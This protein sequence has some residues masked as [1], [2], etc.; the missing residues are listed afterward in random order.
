MKHVECKVVRR[1]RHA[2]PVLLASAVLTCCLAVPLIARADPGYQ[3]Q[4]RIGEP[5]S[6]RSDEFKRDW[7]LE[8]I[9][10]DHAYARGL[11]GRGIIVGM[12]D[13]GVAHWHS[14]LAGTTHLLQIHDPGCVTREQFA[15]PNACFFSDGGVTY[16]WVEPYTRLE[17]VALRRQ[18]K[19]GDI[20]ERTF[21]TIL[22][23]PGLHYDTH[24]THVA[25]SVAA[26]RDGHGMH[27]VA[28]GA[29]L[30]SANK[31]SDSYS[32]AA[33]ALGKPGGVYLIDG[34]RLEARRDV[35]RQ[36]G[37][38]KVRIINS[39]WSTPAS[40]RNVAGLDA[41]VRE[42]DIA[43]R[44]KVY[45]DA[46]VDNDL[47]QVFSVG[48]FAGKIASVYATL[49]RYHPQAESRWLSVVNVRANGTLAPQSGTCG[50]SK[51]WCISAPGSDIYSSV[52]E[53]ELTGSLLHDSTGNLTG[54]RV[55][56]DSAVS[57][58]AT[59]TGTSMAAPHVSGGL[60]LLME[61][62]P[63]LS[64]AQVRDVLLT[65]ARDLGRA[66]VDD[67]YGW[68]MMD[69]KRAIDGPAMLRVDTEVVM[70]QPAG[71]ERPWQDA[72]WDEWRNDI[73]GPGRLV[74]TGEGWLR[75]SGKAAFAGAEIRQGILQ[76]AGHS[77]LTGPVRVDGGDLM[78]SG[79]LN[80]T[81][82]VVAQG[83]AVIVGE[84]LNGVTRV[85]AQG[86]L[87]GTGTIAAT[88]I[89]G[90]IAPGVEGPGLLRIEGDYAQHADAVYEADVAAAGLSDQLAVSGTARLQG[91]VRVKALQ[92][93]PGARYRIVGAGKV[94]GRFSAVQVAPDSA[95][96]QVQLVY[97]DRA[98]DMVVK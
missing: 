93:T 43:A 41:A 23:Y 55:H 32:D 46:V 45:A 68:G 79:V 73:D 69:L 96:V 87:S 83:Q 80:D 33:A 90:S 82:L 49:P 48:N 20:S 77:R 42:P 78:L 60:A 95:P 81:D 89:A 15:G 40:P 88:D 66:G 47:I 4:G 71:G 64:S 59:L 75:V 76:L 22:A 30:Y 9:G 28:F 25:G 1:L 8:A 10:A 57:G 3:E 2:A 53:G 36:M 34:P 62:F 70:D 61:R 44:L 21:N 85:E 51:P 39:A 18:H 92:A 65:T 24:G 12:F 17:V 86:R 97:S 19:R 52:P 37:Q 98:V 74:K 26:H 11:S 6:W 38:H 67:T 54:M 94:E 56:E 27:G 14:E 29:V 5:M 13:S 63:Y 35:Y 16:N 72:A 50:P 31:E 58:Y 84:L 91:V 7:G